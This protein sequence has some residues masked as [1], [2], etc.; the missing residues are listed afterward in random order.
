MLR[1]ALASISH[2]TLKT[3]I[4]WE[5]DVHGIDNVIVALSDGILLRKWE[6]KH[7]KEDMA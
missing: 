3:E 1:H 4:S 2:S 5:D 7:L 6:G